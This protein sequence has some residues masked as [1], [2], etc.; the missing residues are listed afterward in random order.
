[1]AADKSHDDQTQSFVALTAGATVSHYRIVSKIGAGGMGE[2]YLAEDTELDRKVALKFLPAHLCEDEDCRKRFRREAQAAA[3]LSHPGIVTI[4]EVGEHQGRPYF[5]MEHVE[6]QSLRDFSVDKELSIEQILD[7]GIQICEGLNG[8]HEK[9]VTHRDIKPS[10]ILIDSH[11]RAKIVDF[12]LASVV[13]KDQFTKTGSTLGTIGY[14]SPEQVRGKEIDHRS[15]LFSLGVVLYEL[16]TRQNPFKRDSEAATLKAVSDDTPHP[17]ARYRADVPD[18]LQSVVDKALEK[19]VMTRH[20]TAADM[21]SDLK[22]LKRETSGVMPAVGQ[23]PSIAVLPFTNLSADPEQEYFCDGMAEE[24]INALTHVKGLRVVARMSCFAFKGQQVDIREVGQQL[25]VGTVLEG[26]V[27]KAGN[28]LRITAQLVN[29]SDGFHLWSE[30]YDREMEDVFAI[31]DEISLAIVEQSRVRLLKEGKAALTKRYTGDPEAHQLYLKGRYF[32]SQ[33]TINS[34]EKSIVYFKEAILI[35]P[36]YAQAYAG[37]AASYTDL[38]TYSTRPPADVYPLAKEAVLKALEIDGELAEAHTSLGLILCDYEWDWMGAEREF[39]QAIRLNPSY[40]TAHHWYALLLVYLGRVDEAISEIHKAYEL[41]PLSLAVN[42]NF[43]FV[44]YLSHRFDDALEMLHKTVEMDEN[45]TYTHFIMGLAYLRK[46]EFDKAI[47]VLQKERE[48]TGGV[49]PIVVIPM[50]VAYVRMGDRTKAEEILAGI[51][52]RMRHEYVSPFY[53]AQLYFALGKID[54]GFELLER[55]Y[56]ERDI[57]LR[58]I[59]AMP[60]EE[61][62]TKDPRFTALL[63]KMKLM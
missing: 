33:R 4:H 20:Q 50:G 15:D 22:R 44:Y 54:L 36:D 13:G 43:G 55:A 31:Q 51:E 14:M 12:G 6:G 60:M 58:F 46:L 11:G 41:D 61:A 40:E 27:R 57:Y 63:E 38:P 52:E 10:N 2:V 16:I 9:G 34:L 42:R 29:V 49:N 53:L 19:D 23:Q 21:I 3:K 39:K 28:R 5:V 17:V 7:L 8:A 47:D 24:I 37:M 18:G 56:T 25:N 32:W 35:D 48:L 30:R 62:V 59:K 1:M 26:S 45:F